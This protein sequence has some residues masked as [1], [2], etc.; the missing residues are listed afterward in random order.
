MVFNCP[1]AMNSQPKSG[2]VVLS[3]DLKNP[4]MEKLDFVRK[5]S[6]NTYKVIISFFDLCLYL[7]PHPDSSKFKCIYVLIIL[8]SSAVYQADPVGE[9]GSWIQDCG[10][11]AGGSNRY[12]P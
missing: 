6:I 11:G 4:A 7:P 3:D 12:P 10:H 5:W 2:A 1:G 8:L 9:A